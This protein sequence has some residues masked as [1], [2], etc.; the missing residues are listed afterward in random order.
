MTIKWDAEAGMHFYWCGQ[1][2]Q[3][4]RMEDAD[5]NEVKPE[6]VKDKQDEQRATDLQ[7]L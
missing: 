6:T 5:G 4:V 7:Q 1:K 3:Y 2:K